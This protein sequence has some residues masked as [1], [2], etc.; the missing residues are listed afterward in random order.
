MIC[1]ILVNG[2]EFGVDVYE[3][4]FDGEVQVNDT[5]HCK[6][7]ESGR[8]TIFGS[9]DQQI[10]IELPLD[11]VKDAIRP[12]II[13]QLIDD[14]VNKLRSRETGNTYD[15]DMADEYTND[16]LSD[17]QREISNGVDKVMTDKWTTA[18]GLTIIDDELVHCPHKCGDCIGTE[19]YGESC[20]HGCHDC[21]YFDGGNCIHSGCSHVGCLGGE[22]ACDCGEWND[23][24]Y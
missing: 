18:D 16:R 5:F 14:I 13:K 7:H 6:A 12:F 8:D 9:N 23:G 22:C 3:N 20:A 10:V 2:K 11:E 17:L 21:G 15:D 24:R 1:K 4:N 19:L